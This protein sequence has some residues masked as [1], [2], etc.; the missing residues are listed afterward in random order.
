MSRAADSPAGQADLQVVPFQDRHLVG[1]LALSQAVS[2][3]YRAEDWA[4]AAA[5]GRGFVVESDGRVVGTALWWPYGEDF[6]STGMIVVA[7]EAQRQGIGAR[8]MDAVLAD[9]AG[10]SI[11][12]VSTSE[13][14]A[15]YRRLGFV[16]C[17][18]VEQRQ[19]VLAAAPKTVAGVTTRKAVAR[20]YPAI[21]AL[22]RAASGMDRS[23]LIKALVAMAELR[24]IERD[25]RVSG[26]GCLRRWGRGQVIGP[27]VAADVTQAKALVAALAA[28]HVGEFV[29]SDV[30][31]GGGLS[32]CLDEIGLP[33]V[34]RGL[35]MVRGKA[36]RSE[37]STT[38]FALTN[39]SL[40]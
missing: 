25:G 2:W 22:D 5:L 39:Q 1:G 27:V 24:V 18:H 4:F 8:L 31:A 11:L 3:P 34:D 14:E 35:L 26:Y 6:A 10:R 38:L 30:M 15:L 16:P 32:D 37:P 29:R 20:D 21:L 23:R 7:A 28:N 13:G 36:P 33:P 40:G 17:G 9:A 12:L 19:A